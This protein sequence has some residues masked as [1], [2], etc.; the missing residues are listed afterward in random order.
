MR[1]FI[2]AHN[3]GYNP[4]QCGNTITVGELKD[5]LENYEEDTKIYLK[6]NNGYTY[7]SVHGYQFEDD[8]EDEDEE[9][10]E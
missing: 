8:F 2:N 3:N 4:E 6:F 1:I 5:I 10:E 7:G 9:E